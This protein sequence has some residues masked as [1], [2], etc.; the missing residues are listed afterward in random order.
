MANYPISVSMVAQ[1]SDFK[2]SMLTEAS[3]LG[4]KQPETFYAS[5]AT[6][7]QL[8]LQ[9]AFLSSETMA[10]ERLVS[11]LRNP[12]SPASLRSKD[13]QKTIQER[14]FDATANVKIL[15]SQVAMYLDNVW[16]EKLFRQIDSLHDVDEWD[17]DD[18]PI[19][20]SSFNTFLKAIVQLKPERLPGLGLSHSGFLIAAW[21][22]GKNRLTIEFLEKGRVR[23][24]ISRRRDNHEFEQYAGHTS[25]SRLLEGLQPHHPE[26]W[27]SKC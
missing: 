27:F 11:D 8:R 19:R 12:Q 21:T 23:W 5:S 14:L 17:P 26:E 10:F 4:A 24:I 25:V 22:T 16:R 13:D 6:A 15:T 9:E 20:Q 1:T 3:T 2:K 18:A 7:M